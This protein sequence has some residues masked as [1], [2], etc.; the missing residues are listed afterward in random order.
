M[1]AGGNA[2][3]TAD[4]GSSREGRRGKPPPSSETLTPKYETIQRCKGMLGFT[5]GGTQEAELRKVE[6]GAMFKCIARQLTNHRR[7]KQEQEMS[8]EDHNKIFNTFESNLIELV[9]TRAEGRTPWL[10]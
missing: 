9:K 3:P 1:L 6:R 5:G 7:S 10:D 4:R 8:M 2:S